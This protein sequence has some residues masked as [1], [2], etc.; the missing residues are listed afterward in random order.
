MT[1]R[2]VILA[3]AVVAL[4][5]SLVSAASQTVV[6]SELQT[7]TVASAAEE[8]VELYNASGQPVNMNGWKLQY[9]SATG[10]T[11]SQK[12]LMEGSI[13]AYGFYLLA[14]LTYLPAADA[15]MSTGL[16]ASGGHIRLLD[17]DGGV[18]DLLGWGDTANA[19]ET[20]PA[21]SPR[22]GESLERLAGRLSEDG[23]NA[24]DS[25]NNKTDFLIRETPQPQSTAAATEAPVEFSRAEMVSTEVGSQP[26]PVPP[27][28]AEIAITELLIDPESP[29]TDANDEYIELNNL[30][31]E[32]VDLTGWMLKTGSNFKSSF[33][34]PQVSIAPGQYVAFYSKQTKL[35]LTNTGGAARLLDPSG[36]VVSETQVYDK[37]PSGQA[38][39]E[40]EDGWDWTTQPTP[41]HP[42]HLVIAAAKE[43]AAKKSSGSKTNSAKSSRTPSS[44]VAGAKSGKA[45]SP[46]T[47]M[48]HAEEGVDQPKS[49]WLLGAALGLTIG[50]AAYEYRHDIANNYRLWKRKLRPGH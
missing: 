36:R 4:R 47:M 30:G 1:A 15:D 44:R 13:P 28:S 22:P 7:G 16:A 37:A 3:A 32:T 48:A 18:I 17:A 38:W 10:S 21:G 11:W 27:T 34:L 45:S 14:P 35:A 6:I 19:A 40:F 31:P 50:Y 39:A 41:G 43:T 9:K 49:R 46:A 8:F 24:E 26:D 5:I 20:A 29:Q 33:T 2:N 23:G 42:N 25:D 12:A